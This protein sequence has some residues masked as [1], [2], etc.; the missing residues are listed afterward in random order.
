MRVF[1]SHTVSDHCA[2]LSKIKSAYL[3]H[4]HEHL[5]DPITDE[6]VQ[7]VPTLFIGVYV[8]PVGGDVTP[9]ASHT[10]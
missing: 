10:N 4:R 3:L 5:E 6:W 1:L 9:V 7:T 8:H 2:Q